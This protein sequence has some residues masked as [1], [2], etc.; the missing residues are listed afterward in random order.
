MP[1][2][3][4]A[5][6]PNL[7]E[8]WYYIGWAI[9]SGPSPDRLPEARKALE[10]STELNPTAFSTW[11]QL[12]DVCWRV[13]DVDAADKALEKARS[14]GALPPPGGVESQQRL[15]DRIKAAHIL[16]EIYHSQGDAAK[17]TEIRAESER[18]SVLI[19]TQIHTNDVQK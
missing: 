10:K 8:A 4:V 19:Q 9:A 11:L 17:E 1:R 15:Q 5:I 6:A 12:G 18:L 2:T 14:L 3:T 7:A 13:H 16:T